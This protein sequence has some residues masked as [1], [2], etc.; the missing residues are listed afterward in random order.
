M[1]KTFSKPWRRC[2][3]KCVVPPTRRRLPAGWPASLTEWSWEISK[4]E[5]NA[6]F[7]HDGDDDGNSNFTPVAVFAAFCA[8]VRGI[9]LRACSPVDPDGTTQR[10]DSSSSIMQSSRLIKWNDLW[11]LMLNDL[12]YSVIARTKWIVLPSLTVNI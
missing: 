2:R 12:F 3:R 5:H 8:A 11:L 7:C 10:W 6:F 9:L 1:T 4:R